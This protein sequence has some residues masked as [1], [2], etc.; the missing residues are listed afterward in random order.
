M[1]GDVALAALPQADGRL[2]LRPVVLLRA[3]PP[4]D[5]L[6]VCGVSSQL[7]HEV[8]DFD[9]AI[10]PEDE[11]F[12]ASG[13]KVPSLVRLGYL[14]TISPDRLAGRMGSISRARHGRLLMRLSR[15]LSSAPATTASAPIP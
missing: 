6:L 11:D 9:D 2:E 1:E 13:L 14:A 4:Y 10:L 7:R 5:D 3:M 8:A 15:H 12:A